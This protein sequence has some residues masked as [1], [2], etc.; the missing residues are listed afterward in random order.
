[1]MASL[2]GPVDKV[3]GIEARGFIVAA[4]VAIRLGAGFVPLRKAGKLPWEIERQDYELEYSSD[5]LEVHRDGLEPGE[6]VLVVDDVLATGGTA[7]AAVRLV[8]RLGAKATGF[9]CIVEL[10]FLGGR[11]KLEGL[12]MVSL[13]GYE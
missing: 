11:R 2:Y 12:E 6:S 3:V 1:A 7:E 13:V 5:A 10:L 4:P 9:A 8:E